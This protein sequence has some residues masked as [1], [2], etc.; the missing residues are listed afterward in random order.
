MPDWKQRFKVDPIKSLLEADD[1]SIKYAVEKEI[2]GYTNIRIEDLEKDKKVQSI[3]K[4]QQRDGSWKYAAKKSD[5]WTELDYDQYETVKQLAE[6]VEKY[7][8]DRKHD[9]IQRV[10]DYF[11]HHQTP[12][13]DIR[14]VY[15]NQ[16]F[17]NFTAVIL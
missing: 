12:E 4:R 2:L 3:I 8:L 13:G 7:R 11:F 1:I 10:A 9:Q 14:G 16:Y 5:V 15:G 6:L 17:P